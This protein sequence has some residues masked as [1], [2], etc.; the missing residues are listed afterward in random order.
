MGVEKVERGYVREEEI[1]MMVKKKMV[2]EGVEEVR[3]LLVFWCL[4]GLG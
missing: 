3:E 4:W 2:W 1:K